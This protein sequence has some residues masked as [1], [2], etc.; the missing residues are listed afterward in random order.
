MYGIVNNAIESLV[1]TNFGDKN[2]EAVLKKK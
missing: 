2:W 1:K